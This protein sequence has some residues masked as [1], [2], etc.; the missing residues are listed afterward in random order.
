MSGDDSI[1]LLED[2]IEH[3]QRHRLADR[4]SLGCEYGKPVEKP[5]LDFQTSSFG[6]YR[7]GEQLRIIPGIRSAAARPANDGCGTRLH[8]G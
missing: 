4:D 5:M 8:L 7:A 1:Q 2:G 3:R 6:R